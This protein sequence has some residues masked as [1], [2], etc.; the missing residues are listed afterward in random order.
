MDEVPGDSGS[1]SSAAGAIDAA[2]DPAVK[3]TPPPRAPESKS[4]AE[5]AEAATYARK[6]RSKR[7]HIAIPIIVTAKSGKLL[8]E[9]ATATLQV[10]AHGCLV[11]LTAPLQV[12]QQVTLANPATNERTECTVSFVGK[13]DAMA[14][15][16]GLEF[17]QPSPF[18]WR[19]HFPPE[20]WNPE[21]RKLPSAV[22]PPSLSLR[23]K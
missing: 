18:F 13:K 14:S 20:D 2:N 3:D 21:D 15:E 22:P 8:L 23:R 9:E 4:S 10:N 7:I 1:W 11:T 19:I 5:G 17:S 6:R 16:I 12:G